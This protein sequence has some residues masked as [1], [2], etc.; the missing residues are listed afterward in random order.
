ML[1]CFL[2][3]WSL[4]FEIYHTALSWHRLDRIRRT[5]KRKQHIKIKGKMRLK[6]RCLKSRA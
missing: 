6:V 3:F 4:A 5:R 1:L 2:I